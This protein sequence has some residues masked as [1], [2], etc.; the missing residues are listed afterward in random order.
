MKEIIYNVTVNVSEPRVEEW[1]NWMRGEHIQQMLGT[2]LFLGA[3]IVRVIGF[4]QGGKTYA[5]QYRCES[6]QDFERYEKEF[7]PTLQARSAELFGEDAQA[8]RTIL[9][10]VES[11]TLN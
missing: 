5:I 9:E 4:E 3:T 8:F 7:A 11:F 10:V 6:M 2:G 1:L